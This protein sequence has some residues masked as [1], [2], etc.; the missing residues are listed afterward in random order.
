MESDEIPKDK[1]LK[2]VRASIWRRGQKYITRDWVGVR[3]N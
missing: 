1:F 2:Y 3:V